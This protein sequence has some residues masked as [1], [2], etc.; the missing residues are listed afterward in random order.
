M[1][2]DAAGVPNLWDV[3]DDPAADPWGRA[4]AR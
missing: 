4:A 2:T 3:P 1:R